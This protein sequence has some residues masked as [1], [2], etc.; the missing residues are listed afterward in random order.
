MEIKAQYKHTKYG[1][2][3][4]GLCKRGTLFLS[5]HRFLYYLLAC[6]WGLVLTV[7]GLIVTFG[8]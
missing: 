3:M 1:N 6:T 2:F 7:F 5:K 8:L 4:F